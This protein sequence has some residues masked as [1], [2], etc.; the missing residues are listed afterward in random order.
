[1]APTDLTVPFSKEAEAS[2]VG[3]LLARIKV[4]P[5]VGATMLAEEH[6]HS[7]AMGILFGRLMDAYYRD[8]ATD[9]LSVAESAGQSLLDAWGV[10][11]DDAVKYIRR[12]AGQAEPRDAAAHAKIVKRDHD[13]RAMLE[14]AADI[15][16]RAT[17][18]GSDP[19]LLAADVSQRSMQVATNAMEMNLIVSYGDLGRETILRQQRAKA[20]RDAGIELGVKFGLR[21]FDDRTHGLKGGELLILSGEPGVGKTAIAFAAA[22]KFAQRQMKNPDDRRM[23]TLIL[24]LE[25]GTEPTG[26]RFAQVEGGIDGGDLREGAVSEVDMAHLAERWGRNKDLPLYFNFSPLLRTNQM[27]AIVVEAIRRHNVGLLVVDH[28]RFVSTEQR[29]SSPAEEDEVKAAYFKT[30]ICRS[31]GVATILLAHTTKSVE[32]RDDRRPTLSDLRGGG[33]TAAHSDYVVFAYSPGAN[34]TAEDLLEGY[35]SMTDGELLWRK[36]RHGLSD[37]TEYTLDA[38]TMLLADRL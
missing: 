11:K 17:E 7:R 26:D 37:T 22:L 27:R 35:V 9:P 8:A 18:A 10:N 29:F 20:A 30:E 5:D 23:G 38:S 3:A 13:R 15:V 4:A 2:V 16:A 25:M 12:L 32:F 19:E 1:M 33:M 21:C 31:L 24:S 34:A 28:M 6:F 36:N 14:L